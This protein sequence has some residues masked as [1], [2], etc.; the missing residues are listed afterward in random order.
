MSSKNKTNKKNMSKNKKNSN[1]TKSNKTKSKKDTN[2]NMDIDKKDSDEECIRPD[3]YYMGHKLSPKVKDLLTWYQP[4]QRTPEWFAFRRGMITASQWGSIT[5]DNPYQTFK[6]V[7]IQKCS[8]SKFITNSAMTWGTKYEEIATMFYEKL[9]STKVIEFGCLKHPKYDFLGAS[10]DG[11]TPSGIMLEIKCPKTRKITGIVPRY[12]WAQIQGQLEVC[13][14]DVCDFLECKLLEYKNEDEYLA[15]TNEVNRGTVMTFIDITGHLS[16]HYSPFAVT[17]DALDDW[18]NEVLEKVERE[19]KEEEKN[20][21]QEPKIRD[22]YEQTY[23][24]L[25][26]YSCV[27]V[28]RDYTWF[29]SALIKLT[30]FWQKVE[31]Y[32]EHGIENYTQKERLLKER[33]TKRKNILDT[34]IDSLMD[35]YN[36]KHGITK[37]QRNNANNATTHD[38]YDDEYDDEDD[39]HDNY[40]NNNNNSNSKCLF[41][42]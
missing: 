28:K 42:I 20:N 24:R 40:D 10:P 6:D 3:D 41:V 31:Y 13:D 22:F 29:D 21:P 26:H 7:L 5:G 30:D 9:K 36:R 33:K 15:D 11:I 19:N 37:R 16:Y 27:E 32:R 34:H 2:K 12:Y 18:E 23:W 35:N 1:K 39:N 38:D 25:D 17:G 4:P 14:L 8:P